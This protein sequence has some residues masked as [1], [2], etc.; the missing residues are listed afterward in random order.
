MAGEEVGG[1]K[2]EVA[3]EERV[4]ARTQKRLSMYP[5]VEG[6]GVR[7]SVATRQRPAGKSLDRSKWKAR[8][9]DGREVDRM[10]KRGRGRRTERRRDGKTRR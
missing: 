2:G 10:S 6:Q 4:L 5:E 7:V 9:V 8:G 1:G 3:V